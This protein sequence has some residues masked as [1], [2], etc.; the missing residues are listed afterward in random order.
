[1][2]SP[3]TA[4]PVASISAI[5]AII[6]ILRRL[7]RCR[8]RL[9]RHFLATYSPAGHFESSCDPPPSSFAACR[10]DT[11]PGDLTLA[12]EQSLKN[13]M[14]Q[15]LRKN[16]RNRVTHHLLALAALE[17]ASQARTPQLADR[18]PLAAAVSTAVPVADQCVSTIS[19]QFVRN[20]APRYQ[21]D[22]SSLMA[23]YGFVGAGMIRPREDRRN[24]GALVRSQ[25]AV[26]SFN[27]D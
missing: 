14:M 22:S 15:P 25:S 4:V 11:P 24:S 20:G 26:R 9:F 19:L 6:L 5:I 2:V 18:Q 7:R 3:A 17:L 10:C 8:W 23:A 21:L 16:F 13:L 12:F 1:L 27:A